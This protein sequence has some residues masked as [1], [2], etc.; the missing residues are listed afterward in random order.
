MT[1]QTQ[2]GPGAAP[3]AI[4]PEATKSRRP[5][6]TSDPIGKLLIMLAVPAGIGFFF[7]IA[8]NLVDTIW[9]NQYPEP[10]EAANMTGAALGRSFGPFFLMQAFSIGLMQ[11][12]TALVANS[13]GA[14]RGD[15]ARHTIAQ[16]MVAGVL[17]GV[18]LLVFAL[19][20]PVPGVGGSFIKLYYFTLSSGNEEATRLGLA[21]IIPILWLSPFLI[22]ISVF[23]AILSA[24]GDFTTFGII[25]VAA[26]FMN[27]IL[28]PILVFGGTPF[29]LYGL[30]V[31]L[32]DFLPE[33]GV[34]GLAWATV[35]TQ[36]LGALVV[37][38][39]AL[40]TGILRGLKITEFIPFWPLLSQVIGQGVPAA[41]NMLLIAG[42]FISIQFFVPEIVKQ[43]GSVLLQTMSAAD[44]AEAAVNGY[45]N[46]ARIEQL[47][48]LPVIGLELALISIVGNNLGARKE[49]R[50]WRV[51]RLGLITAIIMTLTATVIQFAGHQLFPS[52][53]N[54]SDETLA[55]SSQVLSISAFL[56]TAYALI[57]INS[58][59]LQGMKRPVFAMIIN[60]VRLVVGPAVVFVIVSIV[61]PGNL[62][63]FWLGYG[64][65]AWGCGLFAMWYTPGRMRRVLARE[66]NTPST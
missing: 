63:V 66:L 49:E 58:G 12:T 41:V 38:L 9:A 28:D 21:Y 2:D 64:L 51:Y 53:I 29:S 6:L 24:K 46:A 18:T 16:A 59:T 33:L 32:P 60:G 45:M 42:G 17:V 22:V 50:I 37:M 61:A 8:Y 26:F 55:V 35:I 19:F 14:K 11:G 15:Q 5:D 54:R 39:V 34:A 30:A 48:L 44:A 1:E 20:I 10:G 62:L 36:L 47:L 57:F 65:V 4:A 13:L 52:L 7:M 23:N 31:D 25:Q 56:L 43:T 40:R 27:L 3:E